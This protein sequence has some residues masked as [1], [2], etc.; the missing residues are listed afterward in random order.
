[1]HAEIM[2]K[3]EAF[4]PEKM[5]EVMR[6]NLTSFNES[7]SNTLEQ[8]IHNCNNKGKSFISTAKF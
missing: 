2:E 4:K 7:W 1:V 8:V 3:Y 6:K 5:I